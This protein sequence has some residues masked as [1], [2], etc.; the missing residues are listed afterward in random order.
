MDNL[1]DL[2]HAGFVHVDTLEPREIAKASY[3][4]S[5]SKGRVWTRQLVPSMEVP[6][7]F[8]IEDFKPN[9]IVDC[10]VLLKE[11]RA[12]FRCARQRNN[13]AVFD[14]P[15]IVL[16]IANIEPQILILEYLDQA[17][18]AVNSKTQS[19]RGR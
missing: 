5:E 14:I 15:T 3:E 11:F 6:P 16:L 17:L 8:T 1:T 9:Q 19:M 4:V 13:L 10:R 18:M 12:R 7:P 2:S